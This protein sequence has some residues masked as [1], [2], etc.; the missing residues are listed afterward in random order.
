MNK[1]Q[2][3]LKATKENK[4]EDI[5]RL[6]N[7][8]ANPAYYDEDDFTSPIYTA[9]ENEN[10]EIFRLIFNKVGNT[11]SE[12]DIRSLEN[13]A[14]DEIKDILYELKESHN[15][16]AAQQ[17]A[18]VIEEE[19]E[20][21]K[22]R[23]DERQTALKNDPNAKIS[24]DR[25]K[26][27]REALLKGGR[28]AVPQNRINDND[29]IPSNKMNKAKEALEKNLRF[30][31]EPTAM[32]TTQNS[33]VLPPP[34]P[35]PEAGTAPTTAQKKPDIAPKPTP[36]QVNMGRV[37]F[38]L[39]TNNV[40]I[41]R[42]GVE[43]FFHYISSTEKATNP[44]R[45]D[46]II[47]PY[48]LTLEKLLNALPSNKKENFLDLIA[49]LTKDHSYQNKFDEINQSYRTPKT[50]SKEQDYRQ[51]PGY[52]SKG[53]TYDG[54]S[55]T[56]TSDN[57]AHGQKP[58]YESKGQTYDG[59]SST[60]TSDNTAHGQKP[61]YEPEG[62]TY[63][64]YSSTYTSDNTAHGQK[65]SYEPEEQPDKSSENKELSYIINNLRELLKNKDIIDN[66]KQSRKHVE[67]KKRV[68]DIIETYTSDKIPLTMKER[69]KLTTTPIVEA[70]LNELNKWC[71]QTIETEKSVFWKNIGNFIKYSITGNKDKANFYKD[72][73]K[74]S[75]QNTKKAIDTIK[76]SISNP[77]FS[78]T[79]PLPNKNQGVR[80]RG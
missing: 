14:N 55:S 27:A 72:A 26:A 71:E 68:E 31:Q 67:F 32:S 1:D 25:M 58:S 76:E 80:G 20:Q 52:E 22:K 64:G 10:T 5:K 38:F 75:V 53:Q 36:K 29:R 39:T 65:P 57:T 48:K 44:A 73:I 69:Q 61:S 41:H 62:Q 60:Y 56:Y 47:K 77:T 54:Y 19:G 50:K 45:V 3:L 21:V 42:F 23:I 11:L 7:E 70:K 37:R 28:F 35:M 51:K 78:S 74:N 15:L 43:D 59:Y 63:D 6:L 13:I 18:K 34:P 12:S 66:L 8:G 2:E 24:S 33:F 4:I 49:P 40:D 30:Q 9:A 17:H 16:N 79:T 46:K